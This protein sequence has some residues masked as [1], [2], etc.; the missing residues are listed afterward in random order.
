MY[1]I[2]SF[3]L[4]YSIGLLLALS[5]LY[6]LAPHRKKAKLIDT[7]HYPTLLVKRDQQRTLADYKKELKGEN[8]ENQCDL[9]ERKRIVA[10]VQKTLTPKEG[11]SDEDEDYVWER[12]K[13]SHFIATPS[14]AQR[15]AQG[16]PLVKIKLQ[17][18]AEVDNRKLKK[19]TTLLATAL[20]RDNR[21]HLFITAAV[22]DDR[23]IPVKLRALDMDFLPGIYC[24]DMGDHMYQEAE[25]YLIDQALKSVNFQEVTA[26]GRRLYKVY[27]SKQKVLLSRERRF[28]LVAPLEKNEIKKT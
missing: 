8:A 26:L 19:G 4:K 3:K 13:D 15:V 1:K 5:V 2:P 11:R 16:Q 14:F 22:K 20:L 27:K 9:K 21:C 12:E 24:E 23:T 25:I 7:M 28:Y 10:K 17:E 6:W 18:D